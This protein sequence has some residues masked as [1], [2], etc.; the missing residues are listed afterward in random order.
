VG[1]FLGEIWSVDRNRN[2]EDSREVILD[3]AITSKDC[4]I[5]AE[6]QTYRLL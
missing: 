3:P 4:W 2:W 5:K 1:A 6:E